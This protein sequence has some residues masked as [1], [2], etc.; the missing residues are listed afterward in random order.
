MPSL[1]LL[2]HAQASFGADDYDV[3]SDHGHEQAKAVVADLQRREIAIHHVVC[4]SLQRQRDTAGPVAGMLGLD[5]VTDAR[6]NEYDTHDVMAHHSESDVRPDQ[7]SGSTAP[8]LS[9]RDFQ[10]IL[11]QALY[12]WIDAGEDGGAD[13]P[14]SAFAERALAALDDAAS[15]LGSGETALVCTSGGVIGAICAALMGL[16]ERALVTFNRVAVNASYS[17]VV[18]GRGGTTVVSFNEHAHLEH[19][20]TSLVTYR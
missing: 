15:S 2:R 10:P 18:V 6:W 11:E 12:A 9:S 5:I 16:P 13:E 17:K 20:G 8:V 1:I 4:G 14:H 3:L 19:D 7:R